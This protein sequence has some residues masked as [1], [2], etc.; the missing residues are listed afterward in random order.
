MYIF[1]LTQHP[2]KEPTSLILSR[3][4]LWLRNLQHYIDSY[5]GFVYKIKTKFNESVE[6]YKGILVAKCYSQKY[7]MD[8]EETLNDDCSHFDFFLFYSA[9][10][11]L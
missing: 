1:S 11:D 2:T 9:M 5:V 7:G 3:R 8:Y 6:C 10:E 4:M